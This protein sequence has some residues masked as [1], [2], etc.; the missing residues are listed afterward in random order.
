MISMV[1]KK[2]YEL[3]LNLLENGNV[4]FTLNNINIFPFDELENILKDNINTFIYDINSIIST[5]GYLYPVIDKL[6]DLSIL[7]LSYTAKLKTTE[8]VTPHLKC[9]SSIFYLGD[10]GFLYKRISNF[11]I[12]GVIQKYISKIMGYN[13]NRIIDLLIT[14]KGL[15]ET[16]AKHELKIFKIQRQIEEGLFRMI[17]NQ[18]P[19]PGFPVELHEDEDENVILTIKDINHIEYLKIIP[20]YINGLYRMILNKMN[21]QKHEMLCEYKQETVKELKKNYQHTTSQLLELDFGDELQLDFDSSDSSDSDLDS[22]SDIEI[23]YGDVYEGGNSQLKN[24]TTSYAQDRLMKRD[25]ELF[26]KQKQG[27]FLA[28]SRFCQSTK[29]RQ[30]M[31]LTNEEM[32]DIK[33]K[34][35]D[36][37]FGNV[38]NYGSDDSHKHNYMCPRYWCTKKGQERPLTQKDIDEGKHGCGEVVQRDENGK[39]LDPK[40]NQHII[41]FENNHY[42]D[43][44]EYVENNPGLS[45]NHPNE[46]LCVPCCF[47]KPWDSKQSK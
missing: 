3:I 42:N 23:E 26:L 36:T 33:K 1:I 10:E 31:V 40:P 9:M 34:Y 28:Y 37:T 18:Q 24:T 8:N 19:N 12:K 6:E 20:I 25:P 15:T 32:E 29:D 14:D 21:K 35:P 5:N 47:K 16:E 30:P 4:T 22:D 11:N 17:I 43:K 38:I 27:K 39:V 2:D 13:D 46:K 7:G 41:S 45:K 44:G